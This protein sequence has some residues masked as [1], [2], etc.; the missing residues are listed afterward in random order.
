MFLNC[1][2][3]AVLLLLAG[4]YIGQLWLLFDPIGMEYCAFRYPTDGSR[5]G[6]RQE[7]SPGTCVQDT[8]LSPRVVLEWRHSH[9]GT[10]AGNEP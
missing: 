9:V 1:S 4:S 8:Q 7:L 3:E 2:F 5:P 6:S 10:L